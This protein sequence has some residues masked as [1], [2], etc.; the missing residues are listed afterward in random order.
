MRP[1]SCCSACGARFSCLMDEGTQD[2]KS[3]A[4]A[5]WCMAMPAFMPLPAAV[6]E[7]TGTGVDACM[8]QPARSTAALPAPAAGCYCP[9][10]LHAMLAAQ[11]LR[12]GGN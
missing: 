10:C 3:A 4:S 7:K 1:V 12:A 6:D 8:P 2:G 9:D 5:C 11:G